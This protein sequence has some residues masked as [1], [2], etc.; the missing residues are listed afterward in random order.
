MGRENRGQTRAGV[1]ASFHSP[2]ESVFR[3][4]RTGSGGPPLWLSRVGGFV[5]QRDSGC[6]ACS[7]KGIQ[8]SVPGLPCCLLT[9]LLSLPPLPSLMSSSLNLPFGSSGEV[10]EAE[11]G[12]LKSRSR[13]HRKACSQDVPGPAQPQRTD[14]KWKYA[15]SSE[16]SAGGRVARLREAGDEGAELGP[17]VRN[18]SPGEE[19]A[20]AESPAAAEGDPS[21]AQCGLLSDTGK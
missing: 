17:D 14:S 5:L 3:G 19:G 11:A 1:D 6:Y 16:V 2:S 8:D 18:I 12:S 20:L 4:P 13:G 7:L 21:R 10:T 9:G 15:E